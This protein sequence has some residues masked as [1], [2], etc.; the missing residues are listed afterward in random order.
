MTGPGNASLP[1]SLATLGMAFFGPLAL[2]SGIGVFGTIVAGPP[3]WL[4]FV[5][6]IAVG[7]TVVCTLLYAAT[8]A[9]AHGDDQR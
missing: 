1:R 3:G 2:F 7:G 8:D 6:M 9:A 5:F 4:V